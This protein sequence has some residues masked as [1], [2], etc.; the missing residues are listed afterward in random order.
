MALQKIIDQEQTPTFTAISLVTTIVVAVALIFI[1]TKHFAIARI[2][3]IPF[4]LALGTLINFFCGV[5]A[6]NRN[7]YWGGRIALIGT[8]LWFL[9]L[10]FLHAMG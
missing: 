5:M 3:L 6:F 8:A 2:L 1:D 7:E 10:G 9:E 4:S